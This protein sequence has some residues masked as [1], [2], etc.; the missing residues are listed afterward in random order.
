MIS[1]SE[2]QVSKILNP[3]SRFIF[4]SHELVRAL[5]DNAVLFEYIY[6]WHK[7]K[8][9]QGNV[10]ADGYFSVTRKMIKDEIAFTDGI[11]R[12]RLKK[13]EKLGVLHSIRESSTSVT[14][15]KINFDV[16]QRLLIQGKPAKSTR[17]TTKEQF[18][19]DI[20]SAAQDWNKLQLVKDNLKPYQ[21]QVLYVISKLAGNNPI[22]WSPSTM[23][24]LNTTLKKHNVQKK[25]I[26]F[27]CIHSIT[28]PRYVTAQT[29][30]IKYTQLL[31]HTFFDHL[32]AFPERHPSERESFESVFKD[33]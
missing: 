7:T 24:L 21:I 4:L 8:T 32:A 22:E 33:I 23:G 9:G 31:I 25:P 10:D 2:Q 28:L 30:P 14:K 17:K 26:D 3:E 27:G 19:A 29:T 16:L 1:E 15:F 13:L 11:I 18:Y 20:T 12:R 6:N 5:Q